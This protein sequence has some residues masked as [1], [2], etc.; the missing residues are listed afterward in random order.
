MPESKKSTIGE[1]IGIPDDDRGLNAS[2]AM[3]S[4]RSMHSSTG[5]PM[6]HKPEAIIPPAYVNFE[7]SSGA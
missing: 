2:V 7:D 1:M 6:I 4:T 5:K 3:L